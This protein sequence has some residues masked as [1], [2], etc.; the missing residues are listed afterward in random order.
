M[1]T[2][3]GCVR[4]SPA[5]GEAGAAD[6]AVEEVEKEVEEWPARCDVVLNK[7]SD[8]MLLGELYGDQ[9]AQRIMDGL[10]DY[11]MKHQCPVINTFD[12]VRNSLRR[13]DALQ[14]MDTVAQEFSSVGIPA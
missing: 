13:D 9:G 14:L 11:A 5:E 10:Q 7:M 2:H 1:R 6:A 4:D 3:A 12:S 8:V